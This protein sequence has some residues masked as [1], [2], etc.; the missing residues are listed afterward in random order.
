M[1]RCG[2]LLASVLLLLG[3]V[4][5]GTSQTLSTSKL[6]VHLDFRYTPGARQTVAAGPQL[7]KI[8]DLSGDMLT[9]A[10]NYKAAYPDG[11]TILRIY[12]QVSYGL[13]DDPEASAQHFWTRVLWPR[14]AQLSAADRQ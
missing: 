12:T 5:D 1:R 2:P 14:L 9:A 3:W 7:L 4:G 10:R 8:L 6:G 11:V 13:Q